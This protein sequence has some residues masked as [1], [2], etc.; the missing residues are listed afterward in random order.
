M[1]AFPVPW[2][3]SQFYTN[4]WSY[5]NEKWE[6]QQKAAN[7]TQILIE[8]SKLSYYFDQNLIST[9]IINVEIFQV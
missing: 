1:K 5:R 6:K 3:L 2:Q 4:R 8:H 9:Q 7:F